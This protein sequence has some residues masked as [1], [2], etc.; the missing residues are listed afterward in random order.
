MQDLASIVAAYPFSQV[1]RLMYLKTLCN[2]NDV[3]YMTELPIA[4]VYAAQRNVLYDLI[5]TKEKNEDFKS[6]DEGTTKEG[7]RTSTVAPVFDM[8]AELEQ[9]QPISLLTSKKSKRIKGQELIDK[10]LSDD[11]NEHIEIKKE[12]TV[13][14][15]DTK[16]NSSVESDGFC[17]ETLAK[18]FIK[19]HKFEQ[20]IKIFKKLSLK[21]PEKSVYFADQIRF[22]ERLIENL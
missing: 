11:E 15:V 8:T 5:F 9:M 6:K 3:C 22:F 7:V 18:I 1:F 13:T 19:Q 21:N 17:T 16:S 4:S 10:F 14:Q 2:I 12:T 20:A